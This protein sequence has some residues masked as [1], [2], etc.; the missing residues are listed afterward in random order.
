LIDA[1]F[2]GVKDQKNK[3]R[4][5]MM[6]K[7]EQNLKK[8]QNTSVE[9]FK[10]ITRKGFSCKQIMLR[11]K[12]IYRYTSI[13]II[14]EKDYCDDKFLEVYKHSI[15]VKNEINQSNTFDFTIIF[16]PENKNLDKTHLLADGYIMSYGGIPK[17]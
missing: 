11:V 15:S 8:A 4:Q 2:K 6:D 3:N 16:T 12:D 5:I 17:S 13:Y 7:L 14:D 1:Y 10:F 9:V